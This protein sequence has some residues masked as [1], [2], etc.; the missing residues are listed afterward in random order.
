MIHL[1]LRTALIGSAIGFAIL[2]IG[3]LLA[4]TGAFDTCHCNCN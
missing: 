4:A 3:T 2:I 1:G